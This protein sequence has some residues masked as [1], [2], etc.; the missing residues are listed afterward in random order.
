M[1]EVEK[2]VRNTKGAKKVMITVDGQEVPRV[3]YIR[4]LFAG[5]QT[6]EQ[7]RA[8]LS[9]LTGEYVAY[10]V[11][12]AA[13]RAK[14]GVEAESTVEEEGTESTESTVEEEAVE[15]GTV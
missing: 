10:Q 7:I 14:K 13:T 8:H 1:S 11:V 6:R 15:E 5:G 3:V 12:H 2:K 9:E 4:E